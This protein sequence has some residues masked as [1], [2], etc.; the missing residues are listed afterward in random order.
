MKNG[1]PARTTGNLDVITKGEGTVYSIVGSTATNH[2][3][4]GDGLNKDFV[5]V[6]SPANEMP[7]YATVDVTDD[8]LTYTVKQLDGFI[9]DKFTIEKDTSHRTLDAVGVQIRIPT[10]ENPEI[11]QGLRFINSIPREAYDELVARGINPT[12]YEDTTVGFGSIIIPENYLNGAELTKDTEGARVVPAVKLYSLDDNDVKFTV[13]LTDIATKN[14]TRNYCVVPYIT[15][16]DGAEEITYYGEMQTASVYDIAVLAC[17][18]DSNETEATK[19]Y[20]KTNVL[21]VVDAAE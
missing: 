2:D 5:S 4:L 3:E 6:F 14:Y 8:T 21:D 16:M 7:V 20:L 11:T 13:C 15:V 12:T 19:Q 9:V 10:E 1:E 18:D 17:A